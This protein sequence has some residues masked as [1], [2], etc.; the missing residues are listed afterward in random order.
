MRREE[1]E[2]QE[3]E[4]EMEMVLLRRE[5][6][7]AER[8]KAALREALARQGVRWRK[9]QDGWSSVVVG[10]GGGLSP[11]PGSVASSSSSARTRSVGDG[12]SPHQ[13][14]HQQ[15]PVV[16]IPQRTD[17]F[18][19][20]AAVAREMKE[21]RHRRLIMGGGGDIV[22]PRPL[23]RV[24]EEEGAPL[25]GGALVALREAMARYM[26]P[27]EVPRRRGSR[28]QDAS[29]LLEYRPGWELGDLIVVRP[30]LRKPS[31]NRGVGGLA[32]GRVTE[33]DGSAPAEQWA[34][35]LIQDRDRQN[36]WNSSSHGHVVL[37]ATSSATSGSGPGR[38]FPS[39]CTHTTTTTGSEHLRRHRHRIDTR[40][41]DATL[42]GSQD[43]PPLTR[44]PSTG[45]A[46]SQP[47][48]LPSSTAPPSSVC[49]GQ[50]DSPGGMQLSVWPSISSPGP[51]SGPT[52][53][54]LVQEEKEKDG[55]DPLDDD[56][57]KKNNNGDPILPPPPEPEP[58]SATASSS[59][60][61]TQRKA[62]TP[63]KEEQ[64][65]T[66]RPQSRTA[67]AD[68]GIP[69]TLRKPNEATGTGTGTTRHNRSS[70]MCIRTS[71]YLMTLPTADPA[72]EAEAEADL[73]R[74]AART[75][76]ATLS[77]CHQHH[78]LATTIARLLLLRPV[79]NPGGSGRGQDQGLGQGAAATNKGQAQAQG[80]G[81]KEDK[82]KNEKG[83]GQQQQPTKK[84]KKGKGN[85]DTEQTAAAENAKGNGDSNSTGK[86]AKAKAKADAKDNNNNNNNNNNNSSSSPAGGAGGGGG[87]IE[88]IVRWTRTAAVTFERVVAAYWQLVSPAFDGCSDLRRRVDRAQAT[89]GDVVVCVLAAVFVVLVLSAG[90]WAVRATVWIASVLAEVCRVVRVV[91]GL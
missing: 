28:Q 69:K 15:Q 23:E 32:P 40:P 79:P 6:E 90:A 5:E 57:N 33:L 41:Y 84:N 72:A 78:P 65:T 71:T 17:S 18:L 48:L 89:W 2:E 37:Q 16:L 83:A 91:A 76:Y 59:T 45:T 19:G 43:A 26:F 86:K 75:A 53:P 38:A 60:S 73:A 22:Q 4:E 10:G 30:D 56:N 35:R 64:G 68:W 12:G 27:P 24:E 66:T 36:Q 44:C 9:G 20:L 11:I 80:K 87:S 50:Q 82:D 52:T 31:E 70:P 61:T 42:D 13:H 7:K 39:A 47:A 74:G 14:Q 54:A 51:Q 25:D 46:L 34:G 62:A 67:A 85:E 49:S 21:S 55:I 88:L 8:R 3:D 1:E 58:G 77:R 81:K 29:R 63:T